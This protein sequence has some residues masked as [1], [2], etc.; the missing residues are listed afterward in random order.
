M[1][2]KRL[3]ILELIDAGEISVEEGARR[4]EALGEAAEASEEDLPAAPVGPPG[5]VGAVQQAVFW[6]GG[7][8]L[9]GGALLVGGVYA[10]GI[11]SGWLICGWPLFTVGV[12]V[13]ALAGWMPRAHWLYLNVR[14][15][16]GSRVRLALPLPLRV[17]GWMLRIARPFVPQLEETG[18]D[19]VIEAL[20]EELRAGRPVTVEVDEGED[21]ERVQVYFS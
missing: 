14:Q 2:E 15:E 16:D 21:G 8:L 6:T 4:L 12:L 19:E 13:V 18:A 11:A 17:L 7:A 20:R 3:R 10:W 9:I 5:W 1:E